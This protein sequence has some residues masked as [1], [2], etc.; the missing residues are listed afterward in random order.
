MTIHQPGPTYCSC[1]CESYNNTVRKSNMTLYCTFYDDFLHKHTCVAVSSCWPLMVVVQLLSTKDTTL[2]LFLPI[3]PPQLG[4]GL[5]GNIPKGCLHLRFQNCLHVSH[6]T[7]LLRHS[8]MSTWGRSHTGRAL[9]GGIDHGKHYSS[10]GL[11][12]INSVRNNEVFR[13][14][15]IYTAE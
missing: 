3:C 13:S 8:W 1:N 6:G 14:G 4:C 9:F 12:F 11:W 2:P 15:S 7:D 10:E 5:E